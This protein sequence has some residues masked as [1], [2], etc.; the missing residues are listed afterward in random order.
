ML[1]SIWSV[2]LLAVTTVKHASAQQF[3]DVGFSCQ[4]RVGGYYADLAADCRSY[5]L[6]DPAGRAFDFACPPATRFH[7]QFLVCDHTFRV[8]CPRS[9][10]FFALNELIGQV[11]AR[12][13][14]E[15]QKRAAKK[16]AVEPPRFGPTSNA[17]GPRRP[18]SDAGRALLSLAKLSTQLTRH[19]PP[20][21][22]AGDQ[23]TSRAQRK[24]SRPPASNGGN[25]QQVSSL[26]PSIISQVAA[27]G[28]RRDP[29]PQRPDVR[30]FFPAQSELT[31]PAIRPRNRLRLQRLTKSLQGGPRPSQKTALL[32]APANTLS[33]AGQLRPGRHARR[34]WASGLE[35]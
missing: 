7:Q 23:P 18:E 29:I 33:S 13:E 19:Q 27:L 21:P 1:P 8:D 2:V 35:G 31:D 15:Q 24:R 17:L 5:H 20:S 32:K 3:S 25:R 9:P 11:P 6:C 26:V 34:Q 12:P 16:D 4:G 14:S 10:R 28:A 30:T 22:S